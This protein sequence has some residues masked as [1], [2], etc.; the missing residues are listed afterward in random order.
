MKYG[1]EDILVYRKT[2]EIYRKERNRKI[3][4]DRRAGESEGSTQNRERTK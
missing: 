4:S 2:N 1:K 3:T